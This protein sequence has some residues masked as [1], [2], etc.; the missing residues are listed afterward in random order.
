MQAVDHYSIHSLGIPGIVLMEKAALA[1][2]KEILSR[3]SPDSSVFILAECRNNGGD[4]LALG[5]LLD[6]RGFKVTICEIGGVK[7]P[8][9]PMRY[10]KIF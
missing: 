6:A 7:N 1:M 2:E 9:I 5:R 3:F 8:R 4:G 10:R